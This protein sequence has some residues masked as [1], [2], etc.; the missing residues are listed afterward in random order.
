MQVFPVFVGIFVVMLNNLLG[1]VMLEIQSYTDLK[2]TQRHLY[3]L[4]KKD[5]PA[6]HMV[7]FTTALTWKMA[8]RV[9]TLVLCVFL[10]RL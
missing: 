9:Q 3:T 8:C 7:S 2:L 10:G 5:R 4:K 6:A 1:E